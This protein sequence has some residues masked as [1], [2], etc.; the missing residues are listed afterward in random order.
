[1]KLVDLRKNFNEKDGKYEVRFDNYSDIGIYSV[2]KEYYNAKYEE[3]LKV[4]V[5]MS[6][7]EGVVNDLSIRVEVINVERI[8]KR[9]ELIA[10]EVKQTL[11]K[12]IEQLK[13]RY[14]NV[15][16]IEF[17]KDVVSFISPK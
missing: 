13:S 14:N 11:V 16:D 17:I 1:M 10:F 8:S 9:R 2:S 3:D 5:V 7:E 12:H 15:L 4:S 6:T